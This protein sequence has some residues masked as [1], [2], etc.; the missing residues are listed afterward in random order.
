MEKEQGNGKATQL[1]YHPSVQPSWL[2]KGV[3]IGATDKAT[4]KHTVADGVWRSVKARHQVAP[5][6]CSYKQAFRSQKHTMRLKTK[7]KA[8]FAVVSKNS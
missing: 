3:I 8:S 2:R 7:I 1:V 5:S 6:W 4:C